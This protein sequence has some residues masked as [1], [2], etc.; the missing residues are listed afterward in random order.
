MKRRKCKNCSRLFVITAR[1]PH[2]EYCSRKE[3]QNARKIQW[4]CRKLSSDEDYRKNQAD[5][6]TRWTAK[7]PGYWK[8][9][10]E[11]H[12]ESAHR[13]REKQRDRN[14]IN[15][16]QPPARSMLPTIANMD[17]KNPQKPLISGYYEL[18]PIAGLPFANMAPIIVRIDEAVDSWV[19]PVD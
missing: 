17:T 14:R 4:Q 3:C 8:Q 12:P 2:Q 6:Q 16:R 5:C 10:R 18:T 1:H 13:N 7:N 11:K 19:C 9:Y 15:R